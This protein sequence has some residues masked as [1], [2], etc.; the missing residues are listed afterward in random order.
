MVTHDVIRPK[1][2]KGEFN[3]YRVDKVDTEQNSIELVSV[4]RDPPPPMWFSSAHLTTRHRSC[5]VS[6]VCYEC[7]LCCAGNHA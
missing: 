5:H 2:K 4:Q 6:I 7:V 3:T 1:G